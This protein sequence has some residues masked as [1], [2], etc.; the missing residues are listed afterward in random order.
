VNLAQAVS[1]DTAV[2]LVSSSAMVTLPASVVIP[3][4]A[5][6]AAFAATAVAVT[7]AQAATIT[8]SNGASSQAVSLQLNP[9]VDPGSAALTLG[10][11]SVAFGNVNLNTPATQTVQITSSGTAALTISAA[12]VTGTGFTLAAVAT[13]LTLAPGQSAALELQFNPAAAGAQAGVLTI[14]SNAASG[15][16]STIALSGTGMASSSYAVQLSW[17]APANSDDAVAGYNVYR[18]ANGGAYQKV[19]SSVNQPTTYTDTTVQTGT[20]YTYEV[21]SVDGAGAESAAS[22]VYAAA[23]P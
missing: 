4:G 14:S 20:A 13:P 18:A 21:V 6:S 1:S 10:S 3:A 12:S 2:M 8:A 16:T 22:N 7:A 11:T 5:T 15:G 17:I 19:N 23:I 9:A